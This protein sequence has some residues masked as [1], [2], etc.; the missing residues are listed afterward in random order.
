[1]NATQTPA[2]TGTLAN[3]GVR[4]YLRMADSAQASAD[5]LHAMYM[6]LASHKDDEGDGNAIWD[7]FWSLKQD[8]HRLVLELRNRGGLLFFGSSAATAIAEQMR[9]AA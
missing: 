9:E 8:V 4:L 1:M 7:G 3:P 5:K 6:H 2:V